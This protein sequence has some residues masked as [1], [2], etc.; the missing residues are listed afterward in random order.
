MTS[1]WAAAM[2]RATE[3]DDDPNVDEDLAIVPLIDEELPIAIFP[4]TDQDA[5]V[6]VSVWLVGSGYPLGEVCVSPVATSSDLFPGPDGTAA[7]SARSCGAR[8]TTRSRRFR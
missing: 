4:V 7:T 8:S 5:D 2:L 1:L 3:S 6:E